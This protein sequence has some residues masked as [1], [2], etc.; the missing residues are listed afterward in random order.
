M[1]K[2]IRYDFILVVDRHSQHTHSL[3]SV[4][5]IWIPKR[6]ENEVNMFYKGLEWIANVHWLRLTS[7]K[8]YISENTAI[9]EMNFSSTTQSNNNN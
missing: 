9:F 8:E 6:V 4:V 1:N 3:L 2:H 7:R 5:T